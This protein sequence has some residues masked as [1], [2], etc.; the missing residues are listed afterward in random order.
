MW[1]IR[2]WYYIF[3][4]RHG[5]FK[6]SATV[7][8]IYVSSLDGVEL[9]G[10]FA[11]DASYPDEAGQARLGLDVNYVG[12]GIT[13]TLRIT[14]TAGTGPYSYERF[15]NWAPA[16]AWDVLGSFWSYDAMSGAF[17]LRYY[18]RTFVFAYP[19]ASGAAVHSFGYEANNARLSGW[20]YYAI[21]TGPSRNPGVTPT[22][23]PTPTPTPVVTPTSTPGPTPGPG[24]CGDPDLGN[25]VEVIPVPRVS[26][27]L[28]AGVGPIDVSLPLVG[29]IS[30][31][32]VRV[33]F[34]P[35]WFGT[36]DLFGVKVNLDLVFTAAAGAMILRWF[37]RS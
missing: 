6:F 19:P 13:P 18:Y 5:T 20:Y 34:V 10:Q 2:V 29:G 15:H 28:C 30:V 9:Y 23:A 12:P 7:N 35:V 24:F 17:N 4:N 33:C 32:Q 25:D 37:W 27:G 8:E 21:S 14:I 16:R 36:I 31:P 3:S 1:R 11:M 26:P 22:P